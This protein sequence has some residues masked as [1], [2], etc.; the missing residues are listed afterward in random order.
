MAEGILG[1]Y[2]VDMS[3]CHK[4]PFRDEKF[5]AKVGSEISSLTNV[6]AYLCKCIR[7]KQLKKVPQICYSISC[8]WQGCKRRNLTERKALS[9]RMGKTQR[10]KVSLIKILCACMKFVSR[11]FMSAQSCSPPS[12]S[13]SIRIVP[14]LSCGIFIKWEVLLGLPLR[15]SFLDTSSA[16]GRH[17]N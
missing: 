9:D 17:I 16:S 13:L 6:L 15:N 4:P 7:L 10:C 8:Q 2:W 12:I 11:N 1:W 5:G 14:S 3:R